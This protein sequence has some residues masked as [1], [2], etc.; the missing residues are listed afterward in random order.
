MLSAAISSATEADTT[1]EMVTSSKV[2][3]WQL[4]EWQRARDAMPV[5][6]FFSGSDVTHKLTQ[7]ELS[8]LLRRKQHKMCIQEASLES[9][10]M[11][12]SGIWFNEKRRRTYPACSLGNGCV[13]MQEDYWIRGQSRG[14]I[15]T[16]MMFKYEWDEFMENG[17]YTSQS[18]MC[19]LDHRKLLPAL[20]SKRRLLS[21]KGVSHST[22][23]TCTD[24]TPNDGVMLRQAYYNLIDR[25]NG[26]HKQY[27]FLAEPGESMIEPIV[28]LNRS[29]VRCVQLPSG[30]MKADQSQMVYPDV[31]VAS[32]A[33]PSVGEN[34]ARF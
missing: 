23:V 32:A 29:T 28:R 17:I 18:R 5:P 22:D 30:Q 16:A 20:V 8:E 13:G 2:D 10:L 1:R 34:M 7:D 21:M 31:S 4:T 9:V 33:S 24:T 15:W 27:V 26:Y 12:E 19:V 3:P 6:E 11:V 14:V 25:T